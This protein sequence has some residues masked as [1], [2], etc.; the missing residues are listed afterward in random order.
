MT[1]RPEPVPPA[2]DTAAL[3]VAAA[4]VGIG[5]WVW[6][7]GEIAGWL[8]SGVWPKVP[9]TAAARVLAGLPRHL[10]NPRLAW[11][12]GARSRLPG[13]VAMY[14]CALGVAAPAGAITA[15]RRPRPRGRGAAWARPS[16]LRALR[17]RRAGSGRRVVLGRVSGRLVATESRHS[18]LVIGP[19]QSGKTTGPGG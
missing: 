6:S 1:R 9:V 4:A 10:S 5:L 16:E 14:A 19:T 11:P 7:T 13:G 18:V 2:G 17:V 3:Y 12:A 8:A 15:W